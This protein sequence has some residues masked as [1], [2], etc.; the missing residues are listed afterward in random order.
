MSQRFDPTPGALVGAVSLRH[1]YEL[2]RLAQ[3]LGN[4]LVHGDQLAAAPEATRELIRTVCRGVFQLPHIVVPMPAPPGYVPPDD[5]DAR[6]TAEIFD[7]ITAALAAGKARAANIQ[8]E[9]T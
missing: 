3:E 1:Y 7:F 2:R 4:Q 8:G 9:P 5:P 6:P